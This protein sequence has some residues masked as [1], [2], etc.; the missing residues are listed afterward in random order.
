[1]SVT[2]LVA[3]HKGPKALPSSG[4]EAVELFVGWYCLQVNKLVFSE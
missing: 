1:M 4:A 2:L 3:E